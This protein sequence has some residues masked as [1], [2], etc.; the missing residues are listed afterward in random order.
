MTRTRALAVVVAL[1]AAA[2]TLGGC[3]IPQPLAEVSRVDGG[4]TTTAIILPE[5]VSP[6]TT[7]IVVSRDCTPDP[8]FPLFAAIE[9]TDT[10]EVVE[11]R[12]F[13]DYAP[14]L[15]P[16]SVP[17]FVEGAVP[18]SPDPRI[19][20][21]SLAPYVFSP[22]HY[23]A[24][25]AAALHVVEVVVSN[26]FL[27]LQDQTTQPLARATLPGFSTQTFRWVFQLV[28]ETGHCS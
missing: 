12:W 15:G 14:V 23:G 20:V 8:L 18:P 4:S 11:A 17:Q 19:P 3:P 7:V 16:A 21:R 25:P 26:G 9:D 1:A 22:Y 10:S 28:D 6:S 5:T 27:P 13:V 2:A 24:G